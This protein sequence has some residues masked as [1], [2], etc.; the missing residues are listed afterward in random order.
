MNILYFDCFSGVSGDMLLGA[1][2]ALGADLSLVEK[3]LNQIL[4]QPVGLK[5]KRVVVQGIASSDVT[6]ENTSSAV[7]AGLDEVKNILESSHLSDDE[8]AAAHEVFTRLAASEA[9]VHGIPIEAVHFHE[10]GAIDTLVDVIGF[11]LALRQL[12][13]NIMYCSPLPM[14]RGLVKMAHGQYPLPAPATLELVKGIPCY[15]VEADIELVTPT[16][17]AIVGTLCQGFG[18]FPSMTIGEVGYGAGKSTRSDVP[19]L[20][21]AVLGTAAQ[22]QLKEEVI[23]VI[24]TSIDDMSPEYFSYLFE[25]FYEMDGALDLSVQNIIM[26]K[27][28]PGFQVTCLVRPDNIHSFAD[29]LLTETSTLGVRYRLESRLV[30]PRHTE[31]VVTPWGKAVIKVWKTGDGSVRVAPEYESCRALARRAGIPLQQVVNQ[32]MGS[33]CR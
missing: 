10:L 3:E 25:R 22:S 4:P 8:K 28:R 6:V 23:A 19:N 27:N 14:P 16:G 9:R 13:I 31:E 2:A 17:A 11:L 20:L 33:Y 12:N 29:L 1:L 15:G 32:I 26:K 5:V 24:E 30:Q 21:R 18:T 7:F